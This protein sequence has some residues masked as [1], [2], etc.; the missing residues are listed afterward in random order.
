MT[1][2]ASRG[3]L[4]SHRVLKQTCYTIVNSLYILFNRSLSKCHFLLLCKSSVVIPLF[5][6]GEADVP[7]NYR[8]ISLLSTIGKIIERIIHKHLYNVL[9]S[10]NLIFKQQS[11]FLPGHSTVYQLMDIVH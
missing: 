1:N 6:K 7:S 4:I 3:D 9:V 10:N 8:P 5:K 11:G 2:K